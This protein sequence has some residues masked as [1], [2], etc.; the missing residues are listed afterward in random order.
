MDAEAARGNMGAKLAFVR[1]SFNYF[2]SE[3]VFKYVLEAV[4][5]LAND[6]WRLLPLYSFDPASGL[7]HHRYAPAR[8]LADLEDV[9]RA[10]VGARAHARTTTEAED[11]LLRHYLDEARRILRQVEATAPGER[12]DDPPVT[13][14][15][16]RARWFPLPGEGMIVSERRRKKQLELGL[17]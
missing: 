2:I 13:P 3:A 4:H 14:E 7:W 1:V 6:G 17:G 5:L 9:C 10:S 15:F 12:A 8:P 11:A 16:E